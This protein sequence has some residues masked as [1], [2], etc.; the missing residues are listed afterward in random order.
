MIL[1]GTVGVAA[2]DSYQGNSSLRLPDLEVLQANTGQGRLAGEQVQGGGGQRG[3][4]FG[5]NNQPGQGQAQAERQQGQRGQRR[6]GQQG[7]QGNSSGQ[8]Q[9]SGVPQAA[10]HEW[11][12]LTGE[13]VAA[14]QQGL[15]VATEAAGQLNLAMGPAWFAGQQAI[16]FDSGDVV[17]IIGFEGE[18]GMFQAGQITNDTTG[19]TLHLRDPNGRPL[20]AGQGQGHG[21]HQ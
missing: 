4:G 18:E 1:V 19:D 13:V 17:T 9:G 14:D 15:T 20:W 7:D 12:T 8:G 10:D 11:V 5:Q 6:Q 21:D 3:R 16:S 2:Y